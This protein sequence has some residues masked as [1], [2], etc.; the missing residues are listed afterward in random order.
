MH[1]ICIPGVWF[2]NHFTDHEKLCYSSG[3]ELEGAVG[4]CN[5]GGALGRATGPP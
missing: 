1:S 2:L 4:Q 3:L 5:G